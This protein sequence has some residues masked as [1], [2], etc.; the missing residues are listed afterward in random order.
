MSDKA[1]PFEKFQAELLNHEHLIQQQESHVEKV[2]FAL[3]S[4]RSNPQKAKFSNNNGSC[5][6]QYNGS[7]TSQYNGSRTTQFSP[8][9]SNW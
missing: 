3:Y 2:L 5:T 9:I 6:P 7:R 8:N 4:D 1:I